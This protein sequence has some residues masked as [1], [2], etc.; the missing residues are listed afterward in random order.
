M[1]VL[2]GE[3]ITPIPNDP[4]TGVKTHDRKVAPLTPEAVW[5]PLLAQFNQ[6]SENRHP[7]AFFL[8]G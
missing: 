6:R 2:I 3:P 4:L 5:L 1:R 7:I 8:P